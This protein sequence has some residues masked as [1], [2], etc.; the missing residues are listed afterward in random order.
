M[1]AG[2]WILPA[3]VLAALVQVEAGNRA[4]R[5][6]EVE[7]AVAA[8]RRALE[9]RPDDEIVRYN[10]GTALLRE[11]ELEA[12]L[13]HLSRAT[14]TRDPELRARAYYNLG[15]AHLAGAAEDREGAR[16]AVQ[17]L[18]QALLLRPED[19]DAKWNLELALRRLAEEPPPSA[20]GQSPEGGGGDAPPDAGGGGGG[21]GQ[22]QEQEQPSRP[23]PA[24][25]AQARAPELQPLPR[26][27]AEQLLNAIEEQERALQRERLRR[28]RPA[29]RPAG[30]D[31]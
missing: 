18:R 20:G 28:Q 30:P 19:A 17:A 29:G 10:L 6:G 23:A 14:E 5:R 7:A 26:A 15:T 13:P 31:W 12:A 2:A 24:P 16:R 3:A 4:F 1:S 27:T 9:R 8:Y 11:G 22:A 25:G 21:G